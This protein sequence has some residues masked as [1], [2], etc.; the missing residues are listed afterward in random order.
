MSDRR[1]HLLTYS[2]NLSELSHSSGQIE[3]STVLLFGGGLLVFRGALRLLSQPSYN[4]A[5]ALS[6][7]ANTRD[8][9]ADM[10]PIHMQSCGKEMI[11]VSNRL[12]LHTLPFPTSCSILRGREYQYLP[13]ADLLPQP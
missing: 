4:Q 11:F 8:D 5:M 12:L 9:A 2:F 3:Y 1:Q 7:N 10:L 6:R 13:Q